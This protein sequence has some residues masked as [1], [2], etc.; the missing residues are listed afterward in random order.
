MINRKEGYLHTVA[1]LT[2]IVSSALTDEVFVSLMHWLLTIKVQEVIIQCACVYP[3][4]ILFLNIF[5]P[6][7][8]LT[9]VGRAHN[10]SL[11]QYTIILQAPKQLDV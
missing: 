9:K 7:P 8:G 4:F 2:F 6:A 1:P 5:S 10:Y 11:L 3:Y